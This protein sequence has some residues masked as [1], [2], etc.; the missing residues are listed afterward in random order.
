MISRSNYKRSVSLAI[1]F[2][3]AGAYMSCI[4]PGINAD[5]Q[6]K[7]QENSIVKQQSLLTSTKDT[8]P[9]PT[10]DTTKVVN[11]N[12]SS[13]IVESTKSAVIGYYLLFRILRYNFLISKNLP[14]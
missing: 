5:A 2:A 1:T 11:A 9:N 14:L 4:T 10:G 12:N 3:I 8:K 7:K 6:E 13:R